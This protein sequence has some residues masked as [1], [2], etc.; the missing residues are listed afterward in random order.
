M[1][2]LFLYE[3]LLLWW[4]LKI[5]FILNIF[6][7]VHSL[8]LVTTQSSL[9]AITLT[10]M[11]M[12]KYSIEYAHIY[13]NESS[14]MEHDAY[15]NILRESTKDQQREAISLVVMVDDYS[16]P[17]SSFDY[18]GFFRWLCDEDIHP[19][20]TIRE[21]Q[22]IP[23]CDTVIRLIEDTKLQSQIQNYIVSSKKYPC[24]LFIATWYLIRLWQIPSMLLDTEHRAEHLINILPE[25][26][27]PFEE[28]GF[29]IIK[30]TKYQNLIERIENKYFDGRILF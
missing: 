9:Q 13:T 14:D 25:S 15:I 22:L 2:H 12:K 6:F 19:D 24:S 1:L 18:D 28:R 30:N 17:D 16:F 27:R 21:S 26:F 4:Q 5:V 8:P 7:Y 20:I 10:Q 23:H 29:E 3:N 11:L